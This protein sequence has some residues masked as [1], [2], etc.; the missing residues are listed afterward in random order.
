MNLLQLSFDALGRVGVFRA[1][2]ARDALAIVFVKGLRRSLTATVLVAALLGLTLFQYVLPLIPWIGARPAEVARLFLFSIQHLGDVLAGVLVVGQAGLPITWELWRARAAVPGRSP[3]PEETLPAIWGLAAL[4][5]VTVMLFKVTSVVA[6]AYLNYALDGRFLG[7]ELGEII[8]EN[9]N[10]ILAGYLLNAI[11]A[12]LIGL[13]CC[14]PGL[15]RSASREN[16]PPLGAVFRRA[17]V[18]IFAA[19]LAFFLL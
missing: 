9:G 12:L 3:G 1:Q 14:A 19:K 10:A 6:A 2:P 11:V 4:Y 17:L 5:F 16:E 18:M 15:S 7:G 13:I 8:E